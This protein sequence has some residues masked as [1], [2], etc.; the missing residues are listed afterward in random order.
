M[1]LFYGGSKGAKGSKEKHR[2]VSRFL[3]E[4]EKLASQ[5]FKAGTG[6]GAG[7]AFGNAADYYYGNIGGTPEDYERFAAPEMRNFNENIIPGIS[8]QFAGMGAGGLSSSGFR[9]AA[10]GAGTDLSE[11]LGMIR[12]QLRSQAA[13]GLTNI[14]Q[15]GLQNYSQDQMVQPSSP[16]FFEQIAPAVG[17]MGMS[18]MSQG[19]G[20][21]GNS[22]G[23][24]FS[25]LS[26]MF[27]G[28]KDTSG[29]YN[30]YNGGPHTNFPGR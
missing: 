1:G 18:Y 27:S 6:P 12:A 29:I 17:Q 28:Q 15:I 10:V 24:M 14:G 5:L 2:Q 9:N 21:G 20:G 8:E 19:M 13:Q 26:G 23:G 22:G 4:Q 30:N 11:R 25:G 3:P 7:G 16:G